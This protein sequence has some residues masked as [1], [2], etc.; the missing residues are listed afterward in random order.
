MKLVITKSL[1]QILFQLLPVPDFLVNAGDIELE[2][3][4]TVLLGQ[5][6]GLFGTLKQS[7]CLAGVGG[8]KSN[9][10]GGAD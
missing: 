10:Q 5:G 7:V 1:G 6:H 3:V 8:V 4:V 2:V 9:P